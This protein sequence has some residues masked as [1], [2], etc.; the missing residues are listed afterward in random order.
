MKRIKDFTR[1]NPPEFH[2]SKV[3][4]DLQEFINKVYK[5]VGIMGL[6]TVEKEKL[7]THQ[8]KDIAQ[9]WFEQWKSE[10]V[11]DVDPLDWKKFN[12]GFLD[13]FFYLLTREANLFGGQGRYK[14]R[15]R[16]PGKGSSN[17]PTPK[18]Y[19]D[20]VSNSKPQGGNSGGSLMP[21][22]TR[23]GKNH[24]DKCLADRDGCF[25]CG[26]SVHKMR[27]FPFLATKGRDDRKTYPISFGSS[28]PMQNKFYALQTQQ[29]HNDS[30]NVVTDM[31]KEFQLDAY[32]LLDL[33][34][35]L[36]FVTPYVAMRFDVDPDIL[37]N[38]FHVSTHT[39]D[40]IVAKRVYKNCPILFLI[41]LLML[42]L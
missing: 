4:E 41:E 25:N 28:A 32:A 36:S 21:T 13:C 1:T 3:D 19:K 10:K 20:R 33:G 34:A 14:F 12:G 27:D 5:I 22:W 40:S 37:Y 17:D 26:K 16:F 23:C 8:R 38:P 42:I 35:T 24:D 6:S 2:G 31:L 29:H 30:P 9:V 11:V 39:G 15:Q 7:V 18:F